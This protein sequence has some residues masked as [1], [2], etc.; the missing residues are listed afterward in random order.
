[1]EGHQGS[2]A[3]SPG[4]SRLAGT[5]SAARR[6]RGSCERVTLQSSHGRPRERRASLQRE[7]NQ[8]AQGYLVILTEARLLLDNL[9]AGR[10]AKTSVQSLLAITT[11]RYTSDDLPHPPCH[12]GRPPA[13]RDCQLDGYMSELAELISPDR[14]DFEW[15]KHCRRH[16]ERAS[17]PASRRSLAQISTGRRLPLFRTSSSHT[18]SPNPFLFF[19]LPHDACPCF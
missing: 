13:R 2:A 9:M 12:V 17:T 1:M 3:D 5:T 18:T 19:S 11:G 4:R 15:T 6:A 10:L 7:T 14:K 16:D 8:A